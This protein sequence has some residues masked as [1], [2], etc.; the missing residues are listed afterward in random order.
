MLKGFGA[1]IIAKDNKITI[2]GR[3]KLKA[4]NIEVPADPS[5]AAFLVVAALI[6]PDSKITIKNICNNPARVGLYETLLEMGADIKF[7]NEA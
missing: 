1:D 3:P 2:K 7:Q 4:M 5:S 6:T